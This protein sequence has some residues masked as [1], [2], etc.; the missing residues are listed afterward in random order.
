MDTLGPAQGTGSGARDLE[1]HTMNDYKYEQ[2][3]EE[4]LR[5]AQKQGQVH[6]LNYPSGKHGTKYAYVYTPYGYDGRDLNRRYNILY[7]IHGAKSGTETFLWGE[8]Q[9]SHF[10][11]IIDHGIARGEIAPLIIVTPGFYPPGDVRQYRGQEAELAEEFPEELKKLMFSVESM[12]MTYADTITPEG[13][14]RSRDHRA[15]AGFSMGAVIAWY[16]F[17]GAPRSF[18]YYLPVCGDC[19]AC[20]RF[21]GEHQPEETARWLADSVGSN[22]MQPEDFEIYCATGT[23]DMSYPG[24]TRQTEAMAALPEIF[25]TAASHAGPRNLQMILAQ[26]GEHDYFF[27][28]EYIYAALKCFWK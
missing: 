13:F 28:Y 26:G 3:P 16:V 18:R 20:G 21:G 2:I 7:L 15:I 8:G 23:L 25:R 6:R 17:A 14:A 10:K 12:Y 19:W 11:N 9:N 24:V 27:A 22:A 5:P 4:R 1:R